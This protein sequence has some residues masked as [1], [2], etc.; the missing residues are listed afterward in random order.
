MIMLAPISQF[1]RREQ[2][3]FAHKRYKCWANSFESG[4]MLEDVCHL[5]KSV[6]IYQYNTICR[7]LFYVRLTHIHKYT[8]TQIHT[9]THTHGLILHFHFDSTMCG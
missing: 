8:H 7:K 2:I 1:V 3:P 6:R 9:Y 5:F 4:S